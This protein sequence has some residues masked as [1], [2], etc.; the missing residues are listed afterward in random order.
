MAHICGVVAAKVI[1]S[2]FSSCDVV[3][4]TV[5][6][7]FRG[8]SGAII[9][10]RKRL[11]DKMDMTVFPSFQCG[12]NNRQIVALAV[13]LFHAQTLESKIAQQNIL[14]GANIHAE[15]LDSRGYKIRSGGT[16]NHLVII[17]L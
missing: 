6:K 7:T 12:T 8:S 16:D 5:D 2:P 15:C 9:I 11:E 1:A 4:T 14:M 17:N 13:A 10:F 3:T